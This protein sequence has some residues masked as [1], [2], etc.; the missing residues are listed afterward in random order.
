MPNNGPFDS[1][2][3]II[4]MDANTKRPIYHNDFF[5]YGQFMKFIQRDSYRIS[6]SSKEEC[7]HISFYN[8][9]GTIVLI[10]V[11]A[12]NT[13]LPIHVDFKNKSFSASIPLNTTATFM[14][15]DQSQM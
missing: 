6:S 3:T 9:D 12:R 10:V 13:S 15:K 7:S 8:P 5:M 1:D 4:T 2:F 14:W 11:N